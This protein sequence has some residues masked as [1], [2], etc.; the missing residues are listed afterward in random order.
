VAVGGVVKNSH[1]NAVELVK[2]DRAM[3]V[4]ES[5]GQEVLIRALRRP[6]LPSFQASSVGMMSNSMPKF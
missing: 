5:L 3:L 4:D 1:Q 2:L 6:I